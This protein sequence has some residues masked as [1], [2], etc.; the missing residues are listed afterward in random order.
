MKLNR[1]EKLELFEW[2][3]TLPKFKIEVWHH[4]GNK[5]SVS[6]YTWDE[7]E[8]IAVAPTFEEA[9]VIAANGGEV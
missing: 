1:V 8:P 3:S 2:I 4:P 5:Q 7:E 6:I 9:I